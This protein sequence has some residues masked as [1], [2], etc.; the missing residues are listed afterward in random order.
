MK[1][2]FNRT[3]QLIELYALYGTVVNVSL[4]FARVTK[5]IERDGKPVLSQ[6]TYMP[7]N[8]QEYLIEQLQDKNIPVV[9]VDR[10]EN[11]MTLV[12]RR[13]TDLRQVVQDILPL[14]CTSSVAS[15]ERYNS[16]LE[17]LHAVLSP[18]RS[19]IRLVR[20]TM[21]N[22]EAMEQKGVMAPAAAQKNSCGSAR[23]QC[24]LS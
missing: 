24:K 8:V 2:E 11:D 5:T 1:D 12:G 16:T 14:V 7:K 23:N 21:K 20:K 6:V 19:D 10:G 9:I 13:G 15:Y 3:K 22:L 17:K 4:E 18:F